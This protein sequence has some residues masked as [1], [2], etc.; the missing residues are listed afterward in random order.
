MHCQCSACFFARFFQRCAGCVWQLV[1]EYHFGEKKPHFRKSAEGWEM[2]RFG[3]V[4]I[5]KKAFLKKQIQWIKTDTVWKNTE[6]RRKFAKKD[7]K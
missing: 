2:A 5:N 7:E 6:I 4:I 1:P 3:L